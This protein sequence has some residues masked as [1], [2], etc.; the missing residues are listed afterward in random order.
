MGLKEIKAQMDLVTLT[1]ADVKDVIE[2]AHNAAKTCDIEAYATASAAADTA[3][4]VAKA[5]KEIFDK[6]FEVLESDSAPLTAAMQLELAGLA[7]EA[8]ESGGCD[9]LKE[10]QDNV[11]K[12]IVLQEVQSIQSMQRAFTG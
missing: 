5:S 12:M 8:M 3:G 11:E 2:A 6:S 1:V 4:E 9:F 7:S 10:G